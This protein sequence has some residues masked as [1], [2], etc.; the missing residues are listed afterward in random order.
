VRSAALVQLG[1]VREAI[2]V[3]D[4]IPGERHDSLSTAWLSYALSRD[5][6]VSR[7]KALVT[8]LQ[9]TQAAPACV[10]SYHLAVAHTG[11]GDH[12]SAFASLDRA[13]NERDP[14][15]TFIAGEPR[16][17]PLRSDRRYR[18]IVSALTRQSP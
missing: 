11:L 7:A 2:E 14:G 8:G 13:R 10:S 5:G 9:I 1:R 4:A 15:L 6:Q 16:L 12:D 3:L 17:A 18:Q